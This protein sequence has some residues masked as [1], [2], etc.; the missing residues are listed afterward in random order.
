MAHHFVKDGELAEAGRFRVWLHT[1]Y[2]KNEPAILRF[3]DRLVRDRFLSNSG[4]PILKVLS[5][6]LSFLPTGEVVSTERALAFIDV[7]SRRDKVEIAVGPCRCQ[8]CLGKK[9][10]IYMKDMM[11]LYGTEAYKGASS[12]YK[13]INSEE[14]KA[15]LKQ[16]QEEGTIPTFFACMRSKGWVF[17]ICGCDS[18]ICFPFRA[19]KVAGGIFHPGPDTVALD[20]SKCIGCGM[21]VERCPFD[22]NALVEGSSRV[23]LAQCYGCGL[24]VSTCNGQAR[25]MVNRKGYR[26]HYYPM[27]LVNMLQP[28]I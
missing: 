13:D 22:A 25:K 11:I 21:C 24:C 16:L 9:K 3:L 20:Q 2:A 15:L 26:S 6:A 5:R 1:F 14:A 28:S 7:I 19:H 23:N 17:A 8:E 12:E 18:E 10:G 27:E 4:R